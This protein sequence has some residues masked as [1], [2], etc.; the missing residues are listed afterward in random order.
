MERIPARVLLPRP[1]LEIRDLELVLALAATG[2][3]AG[4]ALA[5]HLTQ[6]AISRAL[7]QAEA[8]AGVRL[9]ER[10]PRGLL[11]TAAGEQLIRAAP[12]L[13]AE[14][15][16]LERRL[17]TPSPAPTH[18]RI[19]CECYT[20]YRWLP[21]T[22]VELNRRLPTL[23]VEIASEHTGNPVAALDNGHVDVALLTTSSIRELGAGRARF[24]ERPLLADEVVFLISAAHALA[25]AKSLTRKDLTQHPLIAPHGPHAYV[26]WFLKSVFGRRPPRLSSLRFPLTEA[27][28]DATRAGM[29]IAVLSEWVADA[30]LT[31]GGLRSKR[32][33][34]GALRRPWHI[35]YRRET[36]EAAERLRAVLAAS[37]PR[38]R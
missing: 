20:A 3:T 22:L 7:A 29:G 36:S 38:V 33:D 18:L 10:A 21:S 27:I 8:R 9:F 11:A 19:V 25:D 4:A 31:E 35:A 32:L 34:T 15:C 6:S 30:Y 26:A 1:K 2:T 17:A 37:A 16:E 13:L 23:T 5:L 14:L 24:V 28:I 12:P